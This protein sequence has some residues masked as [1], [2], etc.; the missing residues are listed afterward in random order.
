MAWPSWS[1]TV[2]H[3]VVFGLRA[4][5]A[6]RSRASQGSTGPI[7]GISP[8]RSARF[9]RLASGTVRV[10]RPANPPGT[11]PPA[12]P[13]EGGDA[14]VGGQDLVRGQLA[15]HQRRVTRILGPPLHSRVLRRRLPAFLRLL[16]GD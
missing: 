4:A 2:T 15:A 14:L 13:A 5:A 3:Q 1:V 7:P 11:A 12:G 9:S 16:R 10:I 6:A 8:G